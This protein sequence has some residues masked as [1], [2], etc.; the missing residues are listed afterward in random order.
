L[1]SQTISG[2]CIS[3]LAIPLI[4]SAFTHLWNPIGF[5]NLYFDEGI[6]MRRA[7]HILEGQGPQEESTFYD[8]PY[9]GQLFLA[10]I[11]KIIGYPD[12][13]NP[14]LGDVHS[15]EMLYLVPRIL[16]GMLAVADTFLIYKISERRYNRNVAFIASVLFAV[17]PLTTWL[18]RWILL[19]TIQL[20][21]LLSS[22][23]FAV[24]YTKESKINNVSRNKRNLSL[25]LLSG[26]FLGLAI[27]TKIPA[28]TM[29]PVVG[30]LVYTQ[31]NNKRV[32]GLW[33][34]P[35]ILIPLIWPIYSI[36]VGGF[37]YW[38][39]GILWQIHRASQPLFGSM[40]IFFNKDPVLL[41]LGISGL[42][43]AVIKKDL[44]LLL[45][46]IPL[47]TF[48]Y[49]IGFVSLYHLIPLLPVFCIAAA[50]FTEGLTRRITKKNV[51]QTFLPFIIIS[52]IGIFGLSSTVIMLTT[53]ANSSYFKAAAFIPQYLENNNYKNAYNNNNKVTIIADAFYLWIPQYIFH[54]DQNYKNY[55]DN[56]P[57]KTEKIILIVDKGFLNA[58]SR[59]DEASKTI[60]K[61]YS[62]QYTNKLLTFQE[63]G[64]KGDQILIYIYESKPG[65]N[66]N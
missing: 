61:I 23:L 4:L 16:M 36:S 56:T 51:Q 5:P 10:S 38:L 35:V 30:F 14:S 11:F 37:N 7:I 18:I 13:L 34:V 63:N 66:T 49:L 44:L 21:F 48:L 22:I 12:S 53:N 55:F 24:Y 32:L 54:L 64:N 6:Y 3:L 31:N 45:W 41:I 26:I 27:F 62:S 8:H 50:R 29:I 19:D 2:I 15:I 57:T 58:M 20:P 25:I 52:G 65:M 47:L 59:N 33:L 43:F 9:F 60:E 28:F 42:I 39:D 46:S 17:M 40:H 1:T